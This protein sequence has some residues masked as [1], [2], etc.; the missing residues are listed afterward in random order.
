[1][2][3]RCDILILPASFSN[4]NFTI[5]EAM[6]SGMGVVISNRVLGIGKIVEDGKNGFNCEPTTEAFLNRIERYIQQPEL[7][8][9]HAEINR[10]L[11]EP[12][13]ARGTA[14]FFAKMLHE[15]LGI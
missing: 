5:L 10:P 3:A 14:K 7:F 12:L 8:R 6:A 1:M 2:Y 4:G 9:V 11:V 13:S 15:R